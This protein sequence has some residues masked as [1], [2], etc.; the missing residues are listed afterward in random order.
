MAKDSDI[1]YLLKRA[2]HNLSAIDQI[3]AYMHQ[4]T[5]PL[6]PVLR[7]YENYLGRRPGSANA[8]FNYAFYLSRD[9]QF[10]SSV[11]MYLRSLKSGIDAPEEVHLNIANIYMDHLN[12]SEMAREHL[13]RSL[14]LNPAYANAYYNLGNLSEQDGNR[15]EASRCFER[16][17][18][19][20]PD[21]ESALA[22]LADAHQFLE[23]NEPLLSRLA[24]TAGNSK[25]SDVH[26]ALGR[27]YEQLAEF[28]KAW[29]H[30]TRANELDM[31]N[32]PPYKKEQAETVF[33]RIR[34]QCSSEWLTRLGGSSEENV[35][36]CGMFRTGSTLLEQVLAAHPKFV[37]GGERQFFP[38][39][40]AKEFK[41][42]PEG[43]DGITT[44]KLDKWRDRHTSHSK[45]LFG[46]S[47]RIT[48]KRPDN[49]LHVGLIK[50]VLPSAKFVVTQRDWRD[51]ATS[52]FSTR[53]GAGQNYATKLENIR[54]YI[55]LQTELIDHW[56]SVLGSDLMRVRYED[57][58]TEPRDTITGLLENL[59]EAWDERCLSFNKLRNTVQTA[60]VW[61][62]REPLHTRS[63]GRWKN[64]F[65]YFESAF[66][67]DFLT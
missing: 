20:E 42:F 54:H 53:L 67:K 41:N 58:V 39:L 24:V 32:L 52:V 62:V 34:A 3:A 44:K 66:G 13:Q 4:K 26:F 37:A 65:K 29:A 60:S 43:L 57:L 49:F 10:E 48:D 21:N 25:N 11:E 38:R 15:D 14:A 7:A 2:G 46:E 28:D 1:R 30:F 63:V 45:K 50:A 55:E 31:P 61:Q 5:L 27:A 12:S 22:R 17:L 35:F 16:C 51:V 56:Q 19:L 23:A 36:I 33:H 59:G 8:A 47:K 64:Y 40:V 18:E 9:G 6:E